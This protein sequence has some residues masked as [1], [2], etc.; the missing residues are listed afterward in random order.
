[1]RTMIFITVVVF[2]AVITVVKR[3]THENASDH[4]KP[5]NDQPV[6]TGYDD[7]KIGL[8]IY[9]FIPDRDMN[10]FGARIEMDIEDALSDLL[11]SH[12]VCRVEFLTVNF[13]L[14][15]VIRAKLD[16]EKA[17]KKG[18]FRKWLRQ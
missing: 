1:M 4:E 12:H 9:S 6:T 8:F 17:V 14:I 5:Y 2:F 18:G 13:Y 10:E 3:R 7:E 11:T 16:P 15:V